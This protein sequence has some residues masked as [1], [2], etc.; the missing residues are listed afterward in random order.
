MSQVSEQ[1]VLAALRAVED[2]E[3]GRDLVALGMVSGVVVKDGNVGFTIEVDPAR[4]A[5]KIALRQLAE[6]TT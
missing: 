1:Q 4:G 3:R 2:P 6:L 5:V